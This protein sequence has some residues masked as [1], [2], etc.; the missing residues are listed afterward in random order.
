MSNNNKQ[1]QPNKQEHHVLLIDG[2]DALPG[3]AKRIVNAPAPASNPDDLAQRPLHNHVS[4]GFSLLKK[5]I[6]R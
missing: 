5:E 3:Q 6:G 4:G 1:P 2:Q